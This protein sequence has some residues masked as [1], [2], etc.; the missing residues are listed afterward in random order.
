MKILI[1]STDNFEREAIKLIKKYR[2]LK[3]ELTDFQQTLIENPRQGTKIKENTYKIRLAVKSKRTGKSGGMRV[4]TF[5]HEVIEQADGEIVVY[6]I[7]IYDKSD[8]ANIS[9]KYLNFLINDVMTSI[10]ST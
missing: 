10:E 9:D 1:A 8:T 7:S 2:S 3:R 5:I 6:L 4:I